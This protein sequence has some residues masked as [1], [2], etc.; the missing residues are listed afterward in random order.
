MG[1]DALQFIEPVAGWAFFV[2]LFIFGVH[3]LLLSYHW[4][5]YGTDRQTSTAALATYLIG[6]ALLFGVM[7]ITLT[8]M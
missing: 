4:F 8:M 6:G 3:A 5:T 7:A 2:L 1:A